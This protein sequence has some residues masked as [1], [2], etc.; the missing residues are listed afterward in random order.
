MIRRSPFVVSSL[1]LEG[2]NLALEQRMPVGRQGM[3]AKAS[4]FLPPD[5]KGSLPLLQPARVV[6]SAS[7]YLDLKAFWENHDKLLSKQQVKDLENFDANSGRYLGGTKLST[8]LTQAGPHQ[9][10]VVA[11]PLKSPYSVQPQQPIPAFALVQEMRDPQFG[12]SMETVLRAGGLLFSLQY[13]L[14]L[15]EEKHGPCTVASYR[16]DEKT[17]LS[18]DDNNVRFNFSPSF[19]IVGDQLIVSSTAE[20]AHDLVTQLSQKKPAKVSPATTQIAVYAKGVADVLRHDREALLASTILNQA[21]PP[22]SARKQI[23]AIIALVE[24]LGVLRLEV[25]YG[26]NDFRHVIRLQLPPGQK[27]SSPKVSATPAEMNKKFADPNL[28]VQDFVKRFEND[29]RAVYAKR[30]E[31]A[32]AVHLRPGDAVADIG[33]GTGLFTLLFAEQ[34]GPKGT[35]Y[36]VDIAPAF[37]KHIAEQVRLH[38]QVRIVKTVLNTQDSTELAAGSINVAFVCDTYHH[39]EHPDKMLASIHRALRPADGSWSL[40]STFVRIAANSSNNARVL[41]RRSTSGKSRAPASS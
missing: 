13:N 17:K 32:R 22:E 31:I 5:N 30:Q 3:D 39:F 11:L 18:G 38:G 16:F 8:L 19:C 20:L 4:V 40:T 41:P 6:A 12:K 34:V 37:L 24:R 35:V 29:T 9:R 23:D 1:S 27:P 10:L 28:D 7:Y 15:V 26:P 33:A 21:L 14:K 2:K 25:Q 36:A